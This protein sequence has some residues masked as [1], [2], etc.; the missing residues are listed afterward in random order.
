MPES[1]EA[2]SELGFRILTVGMAAIGPFSLNIFK[3]CLPFIKAD[4]EAPIEVVQLG[5][6]L[7]VL[8]AAVATAAAGPLVDRV[9]RRPLIVGTAWLYML[10]GVLGTVA[11]TVEILIVAR[12]LQA[13]TSSVAMTVIRAV[14]HDVHPNAER[15]IARVTL[16]A[17]AACLLAPALGGVLIDRIGWRAVFALTAIVGVA[18][19]VPI[20]TS[21]TET[22]PGTRDRPPLEG[23]LA[24]QLGRLLTSGVFLGYSVQSALHFATFFAFTSA[25]TYLMVDVLGRPAYEYGAWFVFMAVFVAAGLGSAERLAGRARAG[26]IALAGSAVVLVGTAVSA[27]VLAAADMELTPLW[28]FLPASFAGYGVGLSLPGTNAGVMDI[29]PELAGTASGLLGFMQFLVAAIFAQ[30][31]VRDEPRT[32][33]V[34][35]ELLVVGGLGSFLFALLSAGH[36]TVAKES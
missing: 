25:S 15:V 1:S 36:D 16:G 8:A 34:L 22:L 28:L 30:L 29:H 35:A 23:T 7:G 31:V 20:H 9:G 12:V 21:L 6:S 27:W 24:G 4:F 13:A 10:S 5:L 2:R 32:A 11:P 18:L 33:Q 26:R 17:V 19:L 3:P 14:V